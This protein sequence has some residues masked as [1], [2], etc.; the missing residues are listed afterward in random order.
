MKKLQ[1]YDP[2]MCCSAGVCGPDVDP[3]LV[4]FAADLQWLEAQDVT[5][6]RFH[7]AQTPVAFVENDVVRAALTEKGEAALPLF[8]VDGKAAAS[9]AYLT[10][11]E[12]AGLL[13]LNG[14]PASPK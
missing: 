12:L 5:V 8:M 4:Q 11:D 6:E 1:I 13:D 3:K 2:P 7:L 14:A 9:G 10:R